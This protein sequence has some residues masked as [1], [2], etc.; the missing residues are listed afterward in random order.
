MAED[1]RANGH[2]KSAP[3]FEARSREIRGYA[4]TIR[5]AILDPKH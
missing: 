1:A 2:L 3:M 5:H 4:E